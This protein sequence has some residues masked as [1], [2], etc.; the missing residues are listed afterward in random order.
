MTSSAR[1]PTRLPG[2]FETAAAPARR[3]ALRRSR[4]P[5]PRGTTATV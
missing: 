5:A 3:A 2:L 1:P 4:T